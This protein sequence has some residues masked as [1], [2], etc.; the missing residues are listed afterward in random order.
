[1]RLENYI[2]DL[3]YRY[4]CV[5][6]PGLGAFLS[7]K[8]SAHINS[9]NNTF[10]PP[11]KRLS[12]NAQLRDNDG[13]LANYIAKAEEISYTDALKR[14]QSYTHTL[15]GQLNEVQAVELKNIGSLSRNEAGKIVFEPNKQT[16]YLTESF[17][18][19]S[20]TGQPISREIYKEQVET[21]EEKAA[22]TLTPEKRQAPAWI[23]YAAIG[24]LA[25]GITGTL[26]Y[27][28]LE[29]VESHNFAQ[30]QKA[31]NELET[32]IQQATFTIN[33]PLPAITINAFKPQGKYHIIAGA[34]RVEENAQTRV[35]ELR[36]LGFKARQIGQNKYGLHQ[37]VYGS[38]TDRVEAL[39]AL[40]SVRQTD[41]KSAWMLVQELD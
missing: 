15:H 18:L 33:N 7:H 22:I 3:L 9:E 34:F 24:L 36:N 32:K 4:E 27:F 2:S 16:N 23:R 35:Q 41:N 26:G 17:G 11:A 40:R 29:N 30:K 12:F 14:I 1:M 20:Y 13:L 25:I 21:L 5:T 38:Y 37:V 8:V 31:Q 19:T 10:F 28:H 6:I 39:K